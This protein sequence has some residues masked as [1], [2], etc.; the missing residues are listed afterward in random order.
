MFSSYSAGPGTNSYDCSGADV[1]SGS[2]NPNG[3]TNCHGT[4]ATPGI[5]FT[6]EIDSAG[7]AVSTSPATGHY[8]PGY[9]YTVKITGTNTTTSSLP[10]WGFQVA[11][12]VGAVAATSPV[13]AGVFQSTGLPAGVHYVVAPGSTSSFFANVVEHDTKLSPA[14]GTGGTG[15]VYTESF[16]WTAPAAGTGV[17]SIFGALNAVNNDGGAS[18][19]DKW[20]TAQLILN[21]IVAAAVPPITGTFNVCVGSTTNLTDATTGGTW[22]SGATGVATVV[23]TTGVVTGVTAGTATITYTTGAG[24]V[25]Q[26]IT[27]NP[28]PAAGTISGA[29]TV[30]QG[31]TIPLSDAATGGTWSSGS[32]TVASVSAS[33]VVSGVGAGTA[34]ISYTVTNPCGTATATHT[35][36]VTPLPTVT[37]VTG[38]AEFCSGTTTSLTD[39]TAGGTWSSGSTSVATV[40]AAG[41]VT[42]V[43]GGTSIISYTL[44]NACG[45]ASATKTVT[46]D[47]LSSGTISG[48]ST[49][50][51]ST[52]TTLTDAVAGGTWSSSNTAIATVGPTTGVV[53]GM[54]AGTANITY[55]VTNTCGTSSST[56]AVTVIA[57]PTVAA[58]SGTAVFCQG[59][60]SALTDATAGG[61]WSSSNT[62]IA[63]V[64][65]STGVVTGVSGGTLNI[66]YTVSYSCGSVFATYP[67]TINPLPIVAAITG[68]GAFCL[69][70]TTTLSDVT[71]SGA[72]SSSNIAVATVASATGMVSSVT[73]GT[74]NISYTVTNGC[75]GTTVSKTVTVDVLPASVTIFGSSTVCQAGTT[76]WTDTSAGGTWSSSNITIATVGLTSG[77]VS[78][79]SP[80]S[81]TITYAI[82]NSCGTESSTKT[83]TINPLPYPGIIHGQSKLCVGEPT[84]LLDG[85]SGGTWTSGNTAI[86]TIDI[87]LGVITGVSHGTTTITYAV[88]NICGNG[89]ATYPVTVNPS[90]TPSISIAGNILTSTLIYPSYGWTWDGTI[91][92]G[93]T[94]QTYTALDSGAYTLVVTDTNG[95]TGSST[96]FLYA[97]DLVQNVAPT[98]AGFHI[99][100]N[101]AQS[102]LFIES[103]QKIDAKLTTID[104]RLLLNIKDV[105]EID[106]TT[107]PNGNYLITVLDNKTGAKLGTEKVLKQGN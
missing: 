11:A 85:V 54:S 14:S 60:T 62:A 88:S 81:A 20:N 99:Y 50:C 101:P 107:L 16:T 79:V 83:I 48:F 66:T 28:I 4:T 5:T 51:L 56:H 24:A 94:F 87:A 27:V 25:T 30:C 7:T 47:V 72:W 63:T 82:V 93:A 104:G 78:G 58:I 23:S 18:A 10:K 8:T 32:P 75:G 39:A 95:C 9:T 97:G 90:P 91:I 35:I 13:N 22:T 6:I 70:T 77:V 40:S 34:I 64:G 29:T 42:G 1:N 15:T 73:A 19:L 21:E 53:T 2:G 26:V 41:L 71:T 102:V 12:T 31:A 89:I 45:S 67:V 69:G 80:G 100:P 37:G 106:L 74:A 65:A 57:S 33:G 92:L 43:S 76:S 3:C 44:T 38:T 105:K 52:T 55:T 36:T 17:V 86:A 84:Q 98:A 68:T 46:V 49:V 103:A 59:T 61:I 96:V